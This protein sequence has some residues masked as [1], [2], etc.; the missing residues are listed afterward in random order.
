[1]LPSESKLLQPV[2]NLALA[3]EAG[4]PPRLLR[5]TTYVGSARERENISEEEG[6]QRIERH[7]PLSYAPAVT[8]GLLGHVAFALKHEVPY[9]GL[10]AAVFRRIT[11]AEVGAYIAAS[12]T[13]AYARRIGYLYEMLTGQD[14]SPILQGV[15]IGG[16]Y[17]ELL[18]STKLVT[19]EQPQQRDARWRIFNN[20][21][22]SRAY[23]PLIERTDAVEYT[24]KHNWRMDATAALATGSGDETLVRRALNYL[25]IKETR[26]SFEIER[27]TPSEARAARFVDALKQA[28]Q[29]SAANAL[30]EKSLCALQN[31]IVDTRYAERG[32]RRIQNYVGASVRWKNIVHFAPPPP[33]S[34][35]A[36]MNGLMQSV[37]RLGSAEP[38]AQ[39]AVASF[40]LVFHHPFED[41]N[42]RLHRY[43]LHDFMTRSKLIPSGLALPV[44]AAILDDL[45]GYDQALEAFSKT[46]GAL[47]EYKMSDQGE[48][49][50]TNADEIGWGWQYP[51]FTPQVEYLGRTL[52]RAVGMIAEEVTYLNKYD[53]LAEKAKRLIDMPD[54]RLTEM[55]S[56]IHTNGGQLSNNKRKQR[57]P[58]LTPEEITAIEAAYTETFGPPA[59]HGL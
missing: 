32:F 25:Y 56:L 14:L 34:L 1:M 52:K 30:S 10:L 20:L 59:N 26:S 49:T 54:L 16:N 35:P 24:L 29:G 39:A 11:T 21:P 22:G 58:E 18:D 7:L 17:A 15:T 45:S 46:V 8:E 19:A 9:L 57:F 12:P 28:G 27:E 50:I 37:T 23:A 42:G 44:S 33:A 38:L 31:L 41:G 55:L 5:K 40:G 13:G 47:V 6:I 43:L 53:A 4:I 51:D 36:L 2:G 3:M 48:M